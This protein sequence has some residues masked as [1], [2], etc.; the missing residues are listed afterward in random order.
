MDKEWGGKVIEDV[1]MLLDWSSVIE[2][3]CLLLSA[4]F[5]IVLCHHS[6]AVAM[7]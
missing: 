7:G 3:K 6:L 4:R 2:Y 1:E 5:S